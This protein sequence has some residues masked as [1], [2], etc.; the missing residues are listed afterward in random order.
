MDYP[1]HFLIL[2]LLVL[3]TTESILHNLD[4]Q[5]LPF[6]FRFKAI[7]KFPSGD[8]SV[9]FTQNRS[10]AKWLL[11]NKQTPLHSSLRSQSCHHNP[12]QFS[13]IIH[14]CP[15]TFSPNDPLHISDLCSQNNN[16][17]AISLRS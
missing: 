3:Q 15:V 4:V 6:R 11:D 10:G 12:P 9:C 7:T 5:N 13:A 8:L 16:H 1:I 2:T 17:K 14:S